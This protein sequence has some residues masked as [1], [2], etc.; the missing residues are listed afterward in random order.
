VRGSVSLEKVAL[1][2]AD[3]DFFVVAA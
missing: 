3:K 2:D 1:L